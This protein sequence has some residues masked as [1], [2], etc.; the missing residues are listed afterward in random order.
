MI[1][2]FVVALGA[3]KP[4][5]AYSE[6]RRWIKT[7]ATCHVQHGDRIDTW[8]FKTCLLQARQRGLLPK[9]GIVLR[10][11]YWRM[12]SKG[13]RLPMRPSLVFAGPFNGIVA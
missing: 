6:V 9:Y 3:I 4:P 1:C 12:L 7:V 8:A 5:L 2:L 10:T 13:T 11:T